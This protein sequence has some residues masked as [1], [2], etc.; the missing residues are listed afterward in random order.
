M[1]GFFYPKWYRTNM[2]ILLSSGLGYKTHTLAEI[3]KLA[4]SIG[5]AGLEIMPPPARLSKEE[6]DRDT[7]Y[8]NVTHAP[9]IHAIGDV[10][11]QA[12]FRA[13]LDASIPIARAAG[14]QTINIHP[15]SLAFGGRQNIIDGITYLKESEEKTGLIFTWEFLVNPQGTHPDRHAFFIEQQA[16]YSIADYVK[17]VKEYNLSATI[18]TCHAGTWDQNPALLVELLGENLAHVHFSDFDKDKKIEHI[19]PGTGHVELK[20]FLLAVQRHRPNITLTVELHPANTK[21][22]VER[23]AKASIEFI[24]TALAQK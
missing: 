16:Y 7:N 4:L 9:V 10:Y 22:E 19:V 17:D 20:E 21:E 23:Q 13:A 5:Y 2:R 18:D 14:A 3:E 15:P 1:W 8:A 6:T 24:T 11:D 12:R